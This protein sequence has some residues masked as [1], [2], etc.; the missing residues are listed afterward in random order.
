M[1]LNEPQCAVK[2][3]LDQDKLYWSR[4][5]SYLQLLEGDDT[6]REGEK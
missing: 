2:Q 1:H 5:K 4:Y 3:A 6:Y